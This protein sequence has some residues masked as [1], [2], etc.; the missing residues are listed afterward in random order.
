MK[1]KSTADKIIHFLIL[2]LILLFL[3]IIGLS[4]YAIVWKKSKPEVKTEMINNLPKDTYL[5]GDIGV[6]RAKTS[7]EKPVSIVIAPYFEYPANDV[8]FEEE[9]VKKKVDIRTEMLAWFSVRTL[10]EIKAMSEAK[11]KQGLLEAVNSLLVMGKVEEIYFEDYVI[12][13]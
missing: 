1:R 5:F 9:L 6:L 3:V 2:L 13:E 7:D 4:I 12:L 11:I 10:E 8:A